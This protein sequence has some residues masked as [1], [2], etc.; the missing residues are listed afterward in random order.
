[1]LGIP[2]DLPGTR[3][4]PQNYRANEFQVRSEITKCVRSFVSTRLESL[5]LLIFR[6]IN[7]I[8]GHLWLLRDSCFDKRKTKTKDDLSVRRR[9]RDRTDDG[10][11]SEVPVSEAINDTIAFAC[12]STHTSPT[13]S[14]SA[15]K[16]ILYLLSWILRL[17]EA[18]TE[19]IS[20]RRRLRSS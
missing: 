2:M 4:N 11:P 7:L 19:T 6:H 8:I 1:M 14:Q 13:R 15:E 20:M 16:S 18:K 17:V 12:N 9:A 10:P 5:Q 3:K